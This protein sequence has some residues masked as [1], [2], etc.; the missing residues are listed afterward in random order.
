MG[1]RCFRKAGSAWWTEPSFL[2][3]M[4]SGITEC[5]SGGAGT[6]PS[7][8]S[9][10]FG[11]YCTN[12]KEKNAVIVLNGYDTGENNLLEYVWTYLYP[13]L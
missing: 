5:C 12:A 7:A 11:Q 8:P 3:Q 2:F 6:I 4:E 13:Y 9:A 1:S 10:A